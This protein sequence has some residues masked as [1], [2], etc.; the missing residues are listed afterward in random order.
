MIDRIAAILLLGCLSAA[1]LA[2]GLFA[3]RRTVLRWKMHH[4]SRRARH[5]DGFLG[6]MRTVGGPGAE[7]LLYRSSTLRGLDALEYLLEER[8]RKLTPESSPDEVRRLYE[9]YDHLGIVDRYID[10]LL[11]GRRWVERVFAAE[12]LGEIGCA[13]AVEPLLEVM[14]NTSEEDRDVRMA[15][16]RALGRIRDPRAIPALIE[17]LRVPESWLPPRVAEVLL[18]FGRAALD[19]LVEQVRTAPEASVRTW[20]AEI[21][22]ALGDDRAVAPLVACLGD[23]NDQVRARAASSLG[24]LGDRRAVSDLMPLMLADPVPF[25]RIQV[26]RA[27]GAIGDERA[28]HHLVDSLNDGAWWVRIRVVE[29]LEQ[30]GEPAVEPLF[31]ALEDEDIEV[32]RRAA[33]TLERLGVLRSLVQKL[34]EEEPGVREKLLAAGQAGA[35]EVLNAALEDPARE[36]RLR[37]SRLAGEIPHPAI[38]HALLERLREEQD[39]GVLAEVITSLARLREP[40]AAEPITGMLGYPSETI[41]AAAVSALERLPVSEPDRLLGPVVRDPDARVRRGAARVLGRVGDAASSFFLRDLLRDSDS[42]VRVEAAASLGL[43]GAEDAVDVLMEAFRDYDPGVQLAVARAL[44]QVGS[45]RCL[46]TLVE[47]LQHASEDLAATIAWAIGR[48]SWPD[49]E[50]LID[51]LFQGRDRRSRLG[52][53]AA[54]RRVKSEPGVALIRSMLDDHDDEVVRHSV[55]TLGELRDEESLER[56]HRLLRS[57]SV[58]VRASTVDA[59]ARIRCAG[60]LPNL[61]EVLA[62][63]SPRVRLRAA[64]ACGLFGR[65]EIADRLWEKLEG[66]GETREVRAAMLLSLVALGRDSDL[67]RLV[68]SL[69]TTEVSDFVTD[70]VN[71]GDPILRALVESARSEGTVEL[72]VATVLDR[73]ELEQKLIREVRTSQDEGRRARALRVL[74]HVESEAAYAAVW[75]SF[76]KDPS[77]RVRTAALAYMKRMAPPEDLFRLLVDGMADLNAGVQVASLR[78]L[79]SFPWERSVPLVVKHL[80][81][82]NP[83]IRE[84]L[85]E[86]LSRLQPA[87]LETFLDVALG[88]ADTTRARTLAVRV[89]A[90]AGGGESIRFLEAMLR[91]DDAEVRREVLANLE[92]LPGRD[93]PALIEAC[94]RDPQESVRAR[95]VDAAAGLGPRRGRK[96]VIDCLDD[97]SPEVRRRALLV[98][99]RFRGG[100]SLPPLRSCLRDGDPRVRSAAVAGLLVL[101]EEGIEER[102]TNSVRMEVRRALGEIADPAAEEKTLRSSRSPA[103]RRAALRTLFFLDEA[104]RRRVLEQARLDPSAGV[105]DLGERLETLLEEWLEEQEPGRNEAT[106]SDASSST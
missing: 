4:L 10:Q 72:L 101:G 41:R 103:R 92:R 60:S 25:V 28:L 19:P 76:Y 17:A 67:E 56:L 13:R 80:D 66:Q 99:S 52:V 5:L 59:L 30:L 65:P 85:V 91:D 36:T 18:Q 48:I 51:R 21:L 33:I 96:L 84:A 20:A 16:S 93:V 77:E 34:K 44:G 12:F 6:Q 53:I 98:L 86:H 50:E 94:R 45:P 54:L 88:S 104:R 8:R 70:R 3:V 64:L 9:T 39:P 73:S 100:A 26:V 61:L 32:R 79:H 58:G 69:E 97:P 46:D 24:K 22:G 7:A 37:V 38:S 49:P 71:R 14:R 105:R 57:P 106:L 47:G 89:V 23:L 87:E 2:A 83:R 68:E 81:A 74:T 75:R 55:E 29:A 35:V 43:L 15:A 102:V 1:A 95:A 42:G 63:P 78:E 27:L 90:C 62:D 31:L 40:G 82:E 11:R